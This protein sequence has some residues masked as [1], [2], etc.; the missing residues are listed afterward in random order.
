MSLTDNGL[1]GTPIGGDFN[2]KK[3]AKKG[4]LD[5]ARLTTERPVEKTIS[6][7]PEQEAE[8]QTLLEQGL[9][10][11]EIAERFRFLNP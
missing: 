6:F 2:P 11:S 8:I 3:T 4:V 10:Y 7:T 5:L 9:S 1:V